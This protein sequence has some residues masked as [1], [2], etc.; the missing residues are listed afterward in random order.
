MWKFTY[1]LIQILKLEK[2]K[3]RNLT[4]GEIGLC[5]NVFGQLINYKCVKIMNHPY[6]PWQPS[7]M[8][9]APEGYIHIRNKH[10]KNDYSQENKNY[11]TI[12]IHEMTH[13]LQYQ[14]NINV[15]LHGAIL[16]TA[17]YLSF[18]LYNP[19][20]YTFQT[21]KK[22]K[23]YNIEQQGEI[24]KDIFLQKVPNIILY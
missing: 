17:R 14:Q 11:Q 22:F 23:Q 6:L 7:Y 24:A 16:Q 19:Y 2:F 18:G 3:Y 8:F 4:Q 9:M 13:I 21:G 5:Q 15:L 1:L 12:F 10:F 20:K